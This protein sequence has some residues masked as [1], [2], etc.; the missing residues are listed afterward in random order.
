MAPR[1]D[2]VARSLRGWLFT[3][4]TL[5]AACA[6]GTETLMP[7]DA[8]HRG[9]SSGSS[10]SGGGGDGGD[11]GNG[12]AAFAGSLGDGGNGGNAGSVEPED[13]G[14]AGSEMTADSGGEAAVDASSDAPM[15][16]SDARDAKVDSSLID[17]GLPKRPTGITMSATS[18]ATARQTPSAGGVSYNDECGANQAL[19]GFKGTVDSAAPADAA[20]G[21]TN[22]RSLQ[23]VCAPLAVTAAEPYR[24]TTGVTT[25]LP[26]RQT[27]GPV[28]QTV[29]CPANQVIIGF[30]GR[31]AAYIEELQ[32]RCAPLAISGTS[33]AFTLALGAIATTGPL[34]AA[35]AGTAF[36]AIDCPANQVAVAQAPRAGTAVDSFGMV[37]R[38]PTLVIQ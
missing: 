9:G 19:V 18:V 5:A 15:D 28:A 31:Q 38:T 3:G 27:P 8:G 37:C 1:F 20:P 24:V 17:S 7:E 33:P 10:S 32:F 22:L 30:V 14:T 16:A 21:P 12:G 23:G 11:G 4:L 26:V 25:L 6:H 13:G 29:T 2:F 35:T 36:A 34:G